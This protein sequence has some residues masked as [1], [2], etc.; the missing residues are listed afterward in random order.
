M[1]QTISPSLAFNVREIATHINPDVD[2]A[3]AITYLMSCGEKLFPGVSTASISFQASRGLGNDAGDD[4]LMKEGRLCVGWGGG[5]FDEHPTNGDDRKPGQCASTLVAEYFGVR[6]DPVWSKIFD[7][8]LA[9]DTKVA[10]SEWEI[11]PLFK[12][13]IRYAGKTEEEITTVSANIM[14]AFNRL[15]FGLYNELYRLEYGGEILNKGSIPTMD[16]IV[17]RWL[18]TKHGI[19]FS[20]MTVPDGKS[21]TAFVANHLDLRKKKE[22]ATIIAYGEAHKQHRDE[23]QFELASLCKYAF[24][25]LDPA[26]PTF[27]EAR[28]ELIE[29]IFLFLDGMLAK[30]VHFHVYCPADF[31]K[32]TTVT[33]SVEGLNGQLLVADVVSDLYEMHKYCRSKNVNATFVIKWST[34]GNVVIMSDQVRSGGMTLKYIAQGLRAAERACEGKCLPPGV[35]MTAEGDDVPNAN[36]WYYDAPRC[37]I[38]NGS[39]TNAKPPTRLS[40]KTVA[41][42]VEAGLVREIREMQQ[43]KN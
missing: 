33:W 26:D 37:Q 35:D 25:N 8:A 29:L 23:S 2:E 21:K 43:M 14:F 4:M 19:D 9:C 11:G 42:I 38:F 27:E 6:H 15:F 34:S 18:V 17:A 22:F 41:A 39:L 40:R 24:Q 10:P 20:Q 5:R 3:V 32:S 31:N 7:Y 12:L 1:S 16:E 13:A 36:Q 28:H 30:Q